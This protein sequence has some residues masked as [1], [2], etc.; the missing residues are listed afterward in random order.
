[1]IVCNEQR[2][3]RAITVVDAGLP[4][5]RSLLALLLQ[6][7]GASDPT[8]ELPIE[9]VA[10][11]RG[12]AGTWTDPTGTVRV[13]KFTGDLVAAEAALGDVW[14]GPSVSRSA[15]LPTCKRLRSRR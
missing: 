4:N 1:M 7:D 9:E 2:R 3:D 11:L 8:D 14:R 5:G 15:R 6:F 10:R 12:Y 13:V